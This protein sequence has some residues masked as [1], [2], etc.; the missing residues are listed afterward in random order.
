MKK[1]ILILTV[2]VLTGTL[3]QNALAQNVSPKNAA[4]ITF[5]FTRQSGSA[6]NQFAVW[7]EDSSGQYVKTLYA[8]RWT[9]NGG[10]QR[11]STAVPLW[12]KQFN[13][14]EKPNEMLD[15]VS[16]ATPRTGTLKYTWDGTNSRGAAVPA[17]DYVLI[18]E[19]TI[20]WENLVYYRAPIRLGQGAA[21]A[22][23]SVEYVSGDRDSDAER[24]MI[25]DV[26]V[27]V[28]R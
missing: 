28:L 4:E 13:L 6:S 14:S 11:R 2:L 1:Y 24:S 21:N 9:A 7:I 23:V 10:W 22:N 16:G 8:T 5:S 27:M 17:G 18:L 3:A 15:V 19:G 12:V 20:R 26:K 25:G